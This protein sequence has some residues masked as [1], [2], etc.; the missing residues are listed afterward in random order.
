MTQRTLAGLL[1]V[2]LLVA[3][4][5][6]ALLAPLPY[7]TYS[8][9]FTIDVLGKEG[10]K[11]VIQVS[12]T[13]AFRDEGQLRFT[14]VFVTQPDTDVNLFE[15]MGAWLDPD[16]AVYPYDSVYTPE[17]TDESSREEGAA[18]MAS[19]QDT[20]IA[21]ALT[22]LGYD[23]QTPVVARV[24]PDSPSVGVMRKGDRILAV[25]GD[26]VSTTTAI[27]EAV[28]STP[29][30][31]PVEVRYERD[32]EVRTAS[33]D[34]EVIDGYPRIGIE[35]TTDFDFPFDVEVGIDPDIGGPSAGL[36]FSLA[37]YDTLTEGSLTG[38]EIVA[39][40]GTI[41]PDGSVGP[42]GGVD[43]KIAAARD[44]GALLFLVPPDNC[45]DALDA[46]NGDMRLVRAETMSDAVDAIE[47]WTADR[48]AEL[49]EC[50]DE[51][52]SARG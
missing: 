17:D 1:A 34:R 30:G 42:I 16:A 25:N 33:V 6:A 51:T 35:M 50:T 47:A 37:I 22:K 4:W 21:V 20:A 7:V 40:T 38:G 15:L 14:T 36:M 31:E 24:T 45:A 11:E 44:D 48:D 8:P 19:S 46:P 9:G 39:G 41:Q 52:G 5:V 32:G 28:S 49:P 12:G 18:E 23:V 2:P 26:D 13:E 3:L 43:Q 10:G 27:G 29:D